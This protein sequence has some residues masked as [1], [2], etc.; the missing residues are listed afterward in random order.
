MATEPA[1]IVAAQRL[2]YQVFTSE[3]GAELEPDN[4]I[5][6]DRFDA[7]CEHFV[8]LD[9][10]GEVVATS[11]LL[12]GEVAARIG[13]FYSEDEFDL[14]RLKRNPGVFAELG[15]TCI[16]SDCRS[17]AA[18]SMLWSEVAQYLVK[19][20]IDYLLGCAS[21]SMLDGGYKAWCVAQQV[22]QEHLAA[23][24]FRVTPRRTLPHL[25]SHRAQTDKVAIPPLIRSYM[26][27]GAEVCGEP[28]WDPA[29][30]CADL[31]VLLSVDRLA[32]RYA[33]RYNLGARSA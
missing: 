27:L 33:R 28:C 1:Q 31:L 2:R 14:D 30:R 23:E 10:S 26:R 18:L 29:F 3:Y 6:Q 22:Q 21:I 12:H 19:E 13:G 24:V 5:D 20:G 9:Q 15:R 17:G 11:R 4:D 32:A 16:R 7:W 25:A 8:V